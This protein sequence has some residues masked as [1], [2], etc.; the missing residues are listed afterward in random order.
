MLCFIGERPTLLSPNR[1]PHPVFGVYKACASVRAR[2]TLS[3]GEEEG[4]VELMT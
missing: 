3:E 4:V 2:R 1:L